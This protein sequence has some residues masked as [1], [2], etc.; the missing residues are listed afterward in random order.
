VPRRRPPPPRAFTLVELS[1]VIA[2]IGL[3]SLSVSLSLRSILSH[4]T[5]RDAADRV[6][7]TDRLARHARLHGGEDATL[8]LAIGARRLEV[9]TPGG[10]APKRVP[11]PLGVQI[12]S[13]RTAEQMTL[14]GVASIPVRAGGLTQTYAVRLSRP[15]DSGLWL[16]FSGLT[17]QCTELKDVAQVDAIFALL[18]QGLHAR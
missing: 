5:L 9:G 14:S 12:A 8:S 7:M 4:S 1:V 2:I 16:M 13:V 6:I 15:D 10:A 3:L 18:P 17:G 11:L